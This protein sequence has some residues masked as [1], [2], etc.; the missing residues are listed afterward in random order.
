MDSPILPS[1]SLSSYHRMSFGCVQSK[2]IFEEM[3]IFVYLFIFIKLYEKAYEAYAVCTMQAY[4]CVSIYYYPFFLY[5]FL[6]FLLLYF[7]LLFLFLLLLFI[8]NF[9]SFIF[10]MKSFF[11]VRLPRKFYG[12]LF[13]SFSFLFLQLIIITFSRFSNAFSFS[14]SFLSLRLPSAFINFSDA[15]MYGDHLHMLY[16]IQHVNFHQHHSWLWMSR[17]RERKKKIFVERVIRFESI[18]IF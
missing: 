9:T 14:L 11:D 10:N 18:Y 8:C 16:A 4:R 6:V 7:L 1:L 17:R 5:S 2:H 12:I 13:Y 3:K 15:C